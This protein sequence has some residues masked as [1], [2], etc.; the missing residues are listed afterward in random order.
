MSANVFVSKHWAKYVLA[1][2]PILAVLIL[3]SLM[4]A[5]LP[6]ETQSVAVV[7]EKEE[8]L[9]RGADASAARWTA[10]G[11][12]YAPDYEAIATINAARWTV[13]AQHFGV[14]PRGHVADA[15]R[16]AAQA[17]HYGVEPRGHVADAAR[18][19]A[20]AQYFGVEPQGRVADAAR[21][22]TLGADYAAKEKQNLQ[23]GIEASAARYSSMDEY[24]AHA[25]ATK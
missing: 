20:Q 23:R 13:Q 12:Y 2:V 9:E 14:E 15:A 18:W 5:P 11:E 16:W 19:T 7:S 3:G 24:Y 8:S 10:M 1:A 21:W 25:A 22:T 4:I 17:Q 6:A